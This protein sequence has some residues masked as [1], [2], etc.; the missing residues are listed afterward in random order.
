MEAK[1]KDDVIGEVS[2]KIQEGTQPCET[3]VFSGSGDSGLVTPS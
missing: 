1:G 2:L 3:S